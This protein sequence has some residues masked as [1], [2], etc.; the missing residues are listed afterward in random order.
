MIQNLLTFD[1]R[2]TIYRPD[3]PPVI[4]PVKHSASIQVLLASV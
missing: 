2:G 3:L 1:R 4:V